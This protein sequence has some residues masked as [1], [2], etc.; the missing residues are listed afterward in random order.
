MKK[1]EV[2]VAYITGTGL[3]TSETLEGSL[4][5]ILT[6]APT[7]SAFEESFMKTPAGIGQ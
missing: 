2:V 6:V 5:E 1:D 4:R 3:K 7:L